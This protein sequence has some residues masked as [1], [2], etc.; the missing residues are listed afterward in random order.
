MYQP[1]LAS[2]VGLGMVR[3][4]SSTREL[5]GELKPAH[6]AKNCIVGMLLSQTGDGSA[7]RAAA[8]AVPHSQWLIKREFSSFKR[9]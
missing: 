2:F 8:A 9:F 5:L 1:E 4:Q 6:S 3:S 7:I